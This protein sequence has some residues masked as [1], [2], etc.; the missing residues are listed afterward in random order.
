M[1]LP[2]WDWCMMGQV[3]GQCSFPLYSSCVEACRRSRGSPLVP[4][5]VAIVTH[6]YVC[7]ESVAEPVGAL[8]KLTTGCMHVAE[9]RTL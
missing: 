8:H 4:A 9:H 2:D 6:P 1:G 7:T 3:A 5:V